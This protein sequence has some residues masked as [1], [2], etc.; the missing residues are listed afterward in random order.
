MKDMPGEKMLIYLVFPLAKRHH[1]NACDISTLVCDKV[2]LIQV[3][4]QSH[5]LFHI[6]NIAGTGTFQYI[7]FEGIW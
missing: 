4:R 7:H 3:W 5:V 2:R 1:L 6:L